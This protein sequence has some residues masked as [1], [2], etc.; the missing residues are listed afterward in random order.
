MALPFPVLIKTQIPLQKKLILCALFSLGTFITI[1]QIIR[2]QT[3]HALVN[4]L[5]SSGII[6][7]S[8]VENNIGIIIAS[9]PPLSPLVR[10]W[11]E[12][13]TGGSSSGRRGGASYAMGTM[14]GALGTNHGRVRLTSA[15]DRG[16][17]GGEDGKVL[18]S[19]TVKVSS[20]RGGDNSSEEFIFDTR[21]STRPDQ[22]RA[23]T[24]VTVERE[25]EESVDAG[26][27]G[28]PFRDP[29]G[30]RETEVAHAV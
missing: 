19:T 11:K 12:K 13:S 8:M 7:W 21:N 10:H 17:R 23:T 1:I 29:R 4:L 22:I 18:S 9:I 30:L 26:R 27:R 14:G 28:N 6:L 3:I 15:N 25:D 16:M 2:I 20:F 24:E 5:Q